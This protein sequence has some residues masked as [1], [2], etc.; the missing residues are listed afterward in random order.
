MHGIINVIKYMSNPTSTDKN[1]AVLIVDRIVQLV[2]LCSDPKAIDPLLDSLRIITAKWDRVSPLTSDERARLEE[3]ENGLRTYLLTKDP[4]RQFTAETLESYLTTGAHSERLARQ[5]L[6]TTLVA[7]LLTASLGGLLPLANVIPWQLGLALMIPLFLLMLHTG[8]AWLYISTLGTFNARVRQAFVY[9]CLGIVL[10]SVT[11]SHY[12]VIEIL[13]LS[14]WEFLQYGGLTFLAAG[15]YF[16]IYVGL[17]RFA[18]LLGIHNFWMSWRNWLLV[19]AAVVVAACL[20]PHGGQVQTEWFFDVGLSGMWLFTTCLAFGAGVAHGIV[21][22][23]TAAYA[24]S[25]HWLYIYLLV[26][27]VG[28]LGGAIALPVVGQLN[29]G[30]LY[31]LI[32]IMGIPPQ[33]LLLYTGYSFKKEAG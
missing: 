4:L 22:N 5:E 1:P 17:R 14:S 29:G 21:K 2:R 9:I 23:V 20:V 7:S 19:S 8:I 15:S 32:A 33:L 10:L 28:S 18:H 31:T 24:R 6:I 11:F 13:G 12:V 26:G 16:L 3:V 25:M 30:F 27:C